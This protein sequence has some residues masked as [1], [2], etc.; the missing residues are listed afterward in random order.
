MINGGSLRVNIMR[1]EDLQFG[2]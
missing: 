1:K 2:K